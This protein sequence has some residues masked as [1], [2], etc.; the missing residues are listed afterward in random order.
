M[1]YKIVV[2]DIGKTNK[3]LFVYD[4]NLQ[5]LNPDEEGVQFDPVSWETPSG[6]ELECDDMG[7]IMIEENVVKAAGASFRMT[8]ETLREL[9]AEAGFTPRRRNFFYELQPDPEGV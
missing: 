5:C 7:S 3:K 6:V 2:L 4:E 8:E 1:S 9:V